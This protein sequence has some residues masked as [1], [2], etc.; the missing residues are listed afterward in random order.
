LADYRLVWPSVL[1]AV[2]YFVWD[3]LIG[4]TLLCASMTLPLDNRSA[5]GALRVAGALCLLGVV[6]P[7][8][9]RMPLQNIAVIGYALALP[10]GA[11]LCLRAFRAPP[12]SRAAA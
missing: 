5:R 11:A 10:V 6:G 12:T 2:E 4:L 9:G 3:I 8:T 1:F 7:L